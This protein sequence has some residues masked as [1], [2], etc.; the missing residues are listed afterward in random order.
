[1]LDNDDIDEDHRIFYCSKECYWTGTLVRTRVIDDTYLI[2]VYHPNENKIMSIINAI[3][4][5][6]GRMV[7]IEAT[8]RHM[9]RTLLELELD[10]Q[11]RSETRAIEQLA[12]HIQNKADAVQL[13]YE[14]LF[15][16]QQ[17]TDRIC[18]EFF[19]NKS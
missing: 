11:F 8:S 19:E 2:K 14:Q 1:M 6:F 10:Y 3:R 9:N 15:A 18:R 17:N 13:A 7:S 16:A 4:N 12:T 5:Q